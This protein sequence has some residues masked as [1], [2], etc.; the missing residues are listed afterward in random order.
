ME[1]RSCQ[2]CKKDFLIEKE[3]FNFYEKIKVPPPT[4]CA[5]C[6]IIRRFLWRNERFL[7]KRKCDAPGHKEELISMYSSGVGCVYDHKF[8]WGDSWNAMDYGKDYDF[9]E[10]FFENFK[11]LM[12]KVPLPDLSVINSVNSDYSN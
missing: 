8:W 1:T 10:S 4:F 11:D 9:S 2:N 6:R 3:D 5:E 12:N 7:H